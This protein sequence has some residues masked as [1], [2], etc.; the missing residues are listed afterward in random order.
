[1]CECDK[2]HMYGVC[3][4]NVNRVSEHLFT[5]ECICGA[6]VCLLGNIQLLCV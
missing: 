6:W 1:M 5:H 3:F 2:V 4:L